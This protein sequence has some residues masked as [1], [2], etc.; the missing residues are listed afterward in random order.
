MAIRYFIGRSQAWLEAELFKCQ[1]ALASGVTLTR[2]D[3]G[4]HGSGAELEV[5]VKERMELILA[6]LHILDAVTYPASAVVRIT[7]TTPQ[8]LK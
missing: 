5:N 1:E 6:E 7:R 8:Y 2:A 4:D 3:T